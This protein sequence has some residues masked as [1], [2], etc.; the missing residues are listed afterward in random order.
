MKGPVT[1]KPMTSETRKLDASRRVLLPP[2][3]N[4]PHPA[5]R[6]E[7]ILELFPTPCAGPWVKPNKQRLSRN[8]PGSRFTP[9]PTTGVISIPN[10]AVG[11]N[12]TKLWTMY[13]NLVFEWNHSTR[14][15]SAP[16][17]F[18]RTVTT[19]YIPTSMDFALR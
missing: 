4:P 12:P 15:R 13:Q 7:R 19:N 14:D 9:V 6:A 18:Y 3:R 8:G 10:L 17:C 1:R 11:Q 2:K 5:H 16:G